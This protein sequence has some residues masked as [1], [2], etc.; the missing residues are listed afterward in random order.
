MQNLKQKKPQTGLLYSIKVKLS[1]LVFFDQWILM[2]DLQDDISKSFWRFKKILP[3]KDRFWADPHIVYKDN[4]Y[5]IFIEEL[6]YNNK[7]G[8]IALI[9]MDGQGNYSKP[10]KILERP[11]HLSYP[12]VFEYKGDYYMI[13]GDATN[14][15]IEV[16][17]CIEFPHK[18]VFHKILMQ[19][20]DAVDATLFYHQGKWWLFA[21]VVENKDVSTYD[22]LFLFYADNPL[23]DRWISHP[24]NPVVSDVRKA[25]PAGKIFEYDGNIY[26][27]AQNGS[28]GYGYGLSFNQIV[29]LN[30]T[31]YKERE[32][33]TVQPTWDRKIKG[34]H[35]FDYTNRLTL[36]DAKLRRTRYI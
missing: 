36:I 20:I 19:H 18:W 33:E 6:L 15:A 14:K 11:Y 35:T 24:Q 13:H 27:P 31:E 16:Y 29:V 12:F 32:V 9:V 7:K 5:Y 34:I 22:E 3:P 10:E 30:E 23:S 4:L 28:K 1:N 21:G 8:H 26:R 25:R 2:F 17:R